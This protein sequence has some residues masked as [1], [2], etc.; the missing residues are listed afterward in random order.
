M[1]TINTS[2]RYALQNIRSIS[3]ELTTTQNRISSGLRV[4]SAKD[5]ATVWVAAEGIRTDLKTHAAIDKSLSTA[6]ATVDAG[7]SATT[8]IA[9]ALSNL[10]AKLAAYSAASDKNT[11]WL[12][13]TAAQAQI[14]AATNFSG[15]KNL[16]NNGTTA[17]SYASSVGAAGA[18][19]SSTITP[20]DVVAASTTAVITGTNTFTTTLTTFTQAE[21]D[22]SSKA[23]DISSSL[24]S[25]ITTVTNYAAA[26][27]AASDR[28]ATQQ[29]MNK[30][31]SSSKETTLSNLVDA[32]LEEE[33]AR[34]QA[35]QTK[36]Q[37]AYQALNIANQGAQNILRLFQ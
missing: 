36:Q 35:L 8:G 17:Y 2:A 28:I 9:S 19:V 14:T 13:V 26:L 25:T 37:L 1:V 23:A 10:N 11:A 7:T 3:D 29:S 22:N 6:K 5:D 15:A 12:A 34:L 24:T 30:A 31:L 32:N 4:A 16:I 21:L 20:V 33:S 27:G 18:V